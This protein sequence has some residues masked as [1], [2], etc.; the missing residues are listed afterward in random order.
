MTA[1]LSDPS[2]VPPK[3]YIAAPDA[4]YVLFFDFLIAKCTSAAS[5]ARPQTVR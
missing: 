1:L 2:V 5:L 4:L 3:Q